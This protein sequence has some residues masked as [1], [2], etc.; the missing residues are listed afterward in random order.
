MIRRKRRVLNAGSCSIKD[1]YL[2]K[3]KK[4]GYIIYDLYIRR[5]YLCGDA[6]A[7]MMK[8]LKER[9]KKKQCVQSRRKIVTTIL[10]CLCIAF[11]WH[12]SLE[13]AELSGNRSLI[14]TR[15]LNDWF[16]GGGCM[17]FAETVVRKLAHFLEYALEGTLVTSVI[18]AYE[19]EIHRYLSQ[20]VLAGVLTA[21]IDE[22]FQ[23]FM[24]GRAASVGDVWI[25]LVGFIFGVLAGVS[26]MLIKRKIRA[27]ALD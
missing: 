24:E 14:I 22:T 6:K 10:L 19:L 16:S 2:C 23:L 27:R 4:I 3:K 5:V 15:T 18:W 1:P 8:G 20:V 25:D 13:E 11:I 21:L 9:E 7:E 17:I 26:W 12:N